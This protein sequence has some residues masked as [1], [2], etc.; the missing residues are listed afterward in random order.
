ALYRTGI[1]VGDYPVDHHHASHPNPANLPEL[2]FYPVPSYSLPMGCLL[3]K[4]MDNFIVAEKSISVTNIVNG[5]TRLQ[6][7]VM[8]IGQ[9]AG[10]LA[11]L[12]I[13]GDISPKSVDLREVQNQL[14]AQGGYLLPY[15]DVTKN[16]PRFKVYQRIGATGILRGT[17][18]NVGWENQTWFFPDQKMSPKDL[19]HAL[20]IF[21]KIKSIKNPKSLKNIDMIEWFKKLNLV[22]SPENSTPHW[23]TNIQN[24]Q[25]FIQSEITAHENINR[26]DFALVIDEL[27]DPFHSWPIDHYGKFVLK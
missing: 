25:D 7:V 23:L 6:P 9:A 15:L 1:A 10:V 20:S 22:F 18:M 21:N 2:H 17:G 12:S 4:G 14:L 27:I 26:G 8:Q 3:P 13:K 5:T 16:H 19:D 24:F 11:A